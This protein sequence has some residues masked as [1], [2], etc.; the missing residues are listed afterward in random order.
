MSSNNSQLHLMEGP[1][2]VHHVGRK[3]WAELSLIA[4]ALNFQLIK[5][6]MMEEVSEAEVPDV[7]GDEY[8]KST[9]FQA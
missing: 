9:A 2:Y 3:K 8:Q 5:E 6:G 4:S 1:Q 7:P